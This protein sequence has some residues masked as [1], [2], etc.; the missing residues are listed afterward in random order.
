LTSSRWSA[1]QLKYSPQYG[2]YRKRHQRRN[3]NLVPLF[4]FGSASM[5]TRFGRKMKP[6]LKIITWLGGDGSE[7]PQKIEVNTTSQI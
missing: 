1:R 4:E 2:R 5:K 3:P 6:A 7:T